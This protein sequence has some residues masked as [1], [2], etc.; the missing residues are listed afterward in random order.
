MIAQHDDNAQE[1]ILQDAINAYNRV[2]EYLDYGDPR[3]AIAAFSEAI[4]LAP[5]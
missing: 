1:A 4:E 5:T 3:Q 2:M